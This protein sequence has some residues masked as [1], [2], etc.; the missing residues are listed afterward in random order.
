M[1]KNTNRSVSEVH[2]ETH[3]KK[4]VAIFLW[5]AVRIGGLISEDLNRIKM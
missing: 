4:S 1:N 5:P 3:R 2:S